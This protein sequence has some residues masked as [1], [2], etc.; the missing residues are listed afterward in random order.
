MNKLGLLLFGFLTYISANVLINRSALESIQTL[1]EISLDHEKYETYLEYIKD[2]EILKEVNIKVSDISE[3]TIDELLINNPTN[4]L[5]PMAKIIQAYKEDM[6]YS[7]KQLGDGRNLFRIKTDDVHV[8]GTL[9]LIYENKEDSIKKIVYDCKIS[10]EVD[11]WIKKVWFNS[12]NI[13]FATYFVDKDDSLNFGL[14]VYGHIRSFLAP[15]DKDSVGNE[16]LRIVSEE[17]AYFIKNMNKKTDE[18][19]VENKGIGFDS[20]ND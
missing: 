7:A 16:T 17:V 8:K 3:E 20:K 4:S 15:D 6:S 18:Y 1:K 2:P 14:N 13:V 9:K 19:S 11:L 12:D 5:E 10:K